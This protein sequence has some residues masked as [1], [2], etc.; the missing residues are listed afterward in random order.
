MASAC[1]I[2][3]IFMGLNLLTAVTIV[4]VQGTYVHTY[5]LNMHVTLCGRI[6]GKFCVTNVM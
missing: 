2:L 5:I 1:K 3:P 6:K 4:E